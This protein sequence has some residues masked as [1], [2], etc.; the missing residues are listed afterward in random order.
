MARIRPETV[1]YWI[2]CIRGNYLDKLV[3]Y[4]TRGSEEGFRGGGLRPAPAFAAGR[5]PEAAQKFSFRSKKLLPEESRTTGQGSAG[6]VLRLHV[7]FKRRALMQIPSSPTETEARPA[8]VARGPRLAI[9]HTVSS[10]R[11]GG[12]E[13]FVVRLAALQ[14]RQG[15]RPAILALRGGPLEETAR[16]AGVTVWAL[17]NSSS[18]SRLLAGIRR[19]ARAH[20]DILHVHNP[21]SLHYACLAKL[22]CGAR[23][24]LTDHGQCAGVA[25]MPGKWEIHRVDALVSVSEDVGA[26]NQ[27]LYQDSTRYIV[28]RNGFEFTPPRRSRDE[29]RR[30]LNLPGGPTGI[31]VARVEPVKDHETLLKAFALLRQ[32]GLEANLLVAG[33]GTE[34]ERL[35]AS[36]PALGLD[37]AR[38]RFLGFRTDVP[39]LLGA[40]D[41][42]ALSSLQEGLPLA[43]LEAMGQELPV[44]ATRVGGVPELISD[45]ENGLLCPTG[46]PEVLAAA[47]KE[48]IEDPALRRRLGQAGARRVAEEFSFQQMARRYEEL[49]RD[50]LGSRAA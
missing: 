43:M 1:R 35:E 49:Y 25:R 2:P 24:L 10:L 8:G 47:L 7:R 44:V 12:M 21:T 36:L 37:P 22:F 19:V 33:D 27:E 14:K 31:V 26:R 18:I 50:L 20:P 13:Q 23:L 28:I 30:E 34:R 41:F 38:I 17:D 11:F 5:G 46:R 39:D 15:H 45:R 9:V 29:V 32:Q 4:G 16:E 42:F 6:V 48:V 3:L 40:A